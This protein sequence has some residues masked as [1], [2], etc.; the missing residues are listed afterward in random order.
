MKIFSFFSGCGI[1]D[2]GFSQFFDISYVNEYDKKFM[3]AY[4]AN[5]PQPEY[6]YHCCNFDDIN[7]S[8]YIDKCGD[9]GF[10]AGPPCPDFSV[11]GKHMGETGKNGRLTTS[12]IQA[13][14]NY[15]PAWFI[16][17]NVKGLVQNHPAY[18]LYIIN[19]LKNAGYRVSSRLCNAL[20]FGVPQFRER[21]FIVGFRSD[22]GLDIHNFNWY[23]GIKYN[24]Q[25]ILVADFP[26]VSPLM[27]Y[28]TS[29]ECPTH[30]SKYKELMIYYWF[31]KNDVENH[32]NQK[33]LSKSS[34]SKI[35]ETLEGQTVT[36]SNRRL[37]RYRYSPTLCYGNNNVFLHP[38]LPRCVTVAESL[39]LQSV[40]PQFVL[41]NHLGTN[42][43][44][45]TVT[46]AVPYL[47]SRAV[48]K[49][50]HSFLSEG[51]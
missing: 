2:L 47:M 36:Q 41:P 6:G 25:D 32:I 15:K 3:L 34:H 51:L 20:E 7:I 22:L 50:I 21:V 27:L 17:E 28:D 9:F 10:I 1:L 43:L 33:L 5:H 48:A 30:L 29:L 11:A 19:E 13:I 26:K 42:C 49:S 39:A 12:Y 24:L 46:N 14:V 16:I 31:L 38:T 18:Y 35:Y 40:P 45:K 8:K 37:H 44:Y 4:T 23:E